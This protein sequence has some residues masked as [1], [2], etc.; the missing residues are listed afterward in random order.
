MSYY[1]KVI[2]YRHIKY[3][4]IDDYLVEFQNKLKFTIYVSISINNLKNLYNNSTYN[5]LITF[6]NDKEE[7]VNDVLKV[8]PKRFINKWI[9]YKEIPDFETFNNK[10]NMKYIDNVIKPRVNNRPDFSI[11]TSCFNSYDK[12]VRAY[13]SV[14]NQT[15]TD[16]EWVVV[17]DS[18]DENHFNFI[19]EKLIDPRIRIYKRSSNSGCIGN[20]K[21]EAIS[22]CRGKYLL[23]LDHDDEIIEDL[24]I[25]AK[26]VFENNNEIGFIYTDFINIQED[27]DNYVFNDGGSICKGYGSYYLQK[28]NNKWVYVYITPNVNNITLSYLICCPNHARIWRR[29]VLMKIENFSEELP[30]CDDYEI[31]LRTSINTKIAKIHKLGYI[32]YMNNN[33]NNFSLIRNKEINRLGPEFIGKQFYDLYNIHGVMQSKSAYEDPFYIENHSD[34]WKRDHNYEHNYCNLLLNL[35]YDKQYCIIGTNSL[36]FNLEKIKNLYLN[37]RNDFIL[38]DNKLTNENLCETIDSFKLEKMKCYSLINNT[39][40]EMIRF[41]HLLYLS[42]KNYEIIIMDDEIFTNRHDI[43]NNYL[44][45]DEKYLEIGIE[46]GDTFLNVNSNYKI[47]VDPDPKIENDNIVKTTSDDFFLKNI[48]SFDVI[49]IDGMHQVE[50]LIN[51]INNSIITLS[52]NGK[53]FIDDVFPINYE[54]Q[55]KIPKKPYFENGIL[56]Y[57]ESWTGDVWKVIYFI[58][59]TYRNDIEYKCFFNENY[60]G[61]LMVKIKNYFQI[62]KDSVD[63]INK[64][65]YNIVFNSYLELLKE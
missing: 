9:H 47:G 22:L 20:V 31:L 4:W 58:L 64:Y 30:I 12:L 3:S 38:L 63:D 29:D 15:F 6:G 8:L 59:Q 25:N 37:K 26:E 21:N 40:E 45:P 13:Q 60:R 51:D 39:K 49:F 5:L 36:I 52:K 42:C 61:V 53:I 18:P 44:N 17:D 7:Y 16:W 28:Y 43:I 24:L 10:I 33:E 56:K 11:F 55:L 19:R 50:Y 14:L 41:F 34:I 23:E 65:D 1:P 48:E 54:E 35:D 46:H 62:S 2:F 32:Q 57:T 27:G